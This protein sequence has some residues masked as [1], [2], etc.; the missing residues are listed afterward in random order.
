VCTVAGAT[1]TMVAAGPCTI[2]A[3]QAGNPTYAAAP[4]VPHTFAI[5]K[6]NQTISFTNPGTKT[7]GVAPFSLTAT[8]SSAL[9]VLF[10]STTPTVCT[11][12]GSTVTIVGPGSCSIDATQVGDT[13]YNAAL[14]QTQAFTVDP[15]AQ[16]I[17]FTNPGPQTFV[18][19]GTI[20]LTA[21]GGASNNPIVFSSST[22][23]VCTVAGAT[24]TMVAAGPCTIT[25]NQA[26]NPTYAA[27]PP[28]PHTFA[29]GPAPTTI[30]VASSANPSFVG[31]LVTFNASIYPTV[32]NGTVTFKDGATTIG[33]ATIFG[34]VATFQTTALS[35]G[36]HTITAIF[37][38]NANYATS[39]STPIVQSVTANGTIT[40]R[41][42]TN[43]GDGSFRFTSPTASLGTTITTTGGTGQST[44]IHLNPGTY[45]VS[46]TMPSGF[47]LTAVTCSDGD[48]RGNVSGASATITLAAA[49]AVTCTFASANSRKKTVETIAHFIARRNDLLL[50]NGPDTDRQ[51]DRLIEFNHDPQAPSAGFASPA[52]NPAEAASRLGSTLSRFE[53]GQPQSASN[54]LPIGPS[55]FGGDPIEPIVGGGH[56]PFRIMG[57]TEGPTT[58]AFSTSLSQM[59]KF[60]TE[61]E[62]AKEQNATL[63]VAPA[64]AGAK[65]PSAGY[66]PSVFDL[67]VDAKY[68]NFTN[69]RS[70]ADISGHFG[71]IYVGADYV[72]NRSLLVGTYIQFDTMRQS[73]QRSAHSVEGRGWMAGPYATLRLTDNLY[74][75]GRAAWGRSSNKVSPYL[76]YEDS[77]DSERWLVASTLKGRWNFGPWQMRPTATI[78]YIQDTSNG[79]TDN[80]GVTIPSIK[81]NLGQVKAGPEF[82]YRHITAD[83][84]TIEPRI[85]VE[86]IYNFSGANVSIDGV[87]SGPT[88]VRGKVETGVRLSLPPGLSIDGSVS[89]DGLG[90]HSY[91]AVTGKV[92]VRV[93]LY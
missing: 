24:V 63:T 69:H 54:R 92:T 79:Y 78:S 36:P 21:T 8:A 33:T 70:G 49:E 1:V 34:G 12:A 31:Q 39:A 57:D 9:P 26:G 61:A 52:P 64:F 65:M 66:R 4:P 22:A 74:L 58:L 18:P 80:L 23:S 5:G 17:S 56:L 93:P 76:T 14:P 7:F 83:G 48:S 3:N 51:I 53:A 62:T 75:Q 91:H 68:S 16:V 43:D 25:A 85:G 47:G 90:A 29:I 41:V 6:A 72:V 71:V 81:T 44:A 82:A 19:S 2:T 67:W 46:I 89:Y 50:S 86:A 42:I 84:V 73:S 20:A 59:R 77:F 27:A 28:V 38:G 30:V 11:V 15:A 55:V 45:G 10:A 88:G 87:S 60:A 37:S 32:M 40:L 13:N 35:S